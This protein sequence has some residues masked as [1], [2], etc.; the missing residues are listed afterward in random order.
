MKTIFG[1][2]PESF[3][4]KM[5]GSNYVWYKSKCEAAYRFLADG[6]TKVWM[7]FIPFQQEVETA[8]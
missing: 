8:V 6:N 1:L 2:V 3:S 5:K 4:F 7:D